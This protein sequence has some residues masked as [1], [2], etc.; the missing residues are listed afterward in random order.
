MH[1]T[2]FKAWD[3]KG[4]RFIEYFVVSKNGKILGKDFDVLNEPTFSWDDAALIQ[5]TGLK[6]KSGKEIYEGDI[7]NHLSYL[8][9]PDMNTEV[10][11]VEIVENLQDFFKNIGIRENDAEQFNPDHLEVIGNIYQNLELLKS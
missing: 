5:Y 7:I 8:N 4:E 6:D 2:K 9:S 1:E 3:K 11:C 10:W